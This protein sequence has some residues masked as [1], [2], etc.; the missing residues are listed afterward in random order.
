[1][2]SVLSRRV[3]P[4]LLFLQVA[5]IGLFA[6]LV[7]ALPPDTAELDHTDTSMLDTA[8][9]AVTLLGIVI[10]LVG[11]AAILGLEKVRARTPRPVRAGWLGV[12]ALGQV[13]IA[14]LALINVFGQDP[15][16]DVVF[17]AAMT[18]AA[19]GIAAACISEARTAVP[20]GPHVQA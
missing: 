7:T 5:Y 12:V 20:F 15:G 16:P 4:I 19:L 2:T 10:A 13:A 8:L 6:V 11:A 1:M 17:G 14:V 18:V 3:A 9:Y